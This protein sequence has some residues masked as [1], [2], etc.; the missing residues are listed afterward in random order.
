MLLLLSSFDPALFLCPLLS[1][2]VPWSLL[3]A[4]LIFVLLL[5]GPTLLSLAWLKGC[6]FGFIFG[7]TELPPP[8]F[9]T[10]GLAPFLD[11][12]SA[13]AHRI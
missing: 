13:L 11:F 8:K 4:S 3:E 6:R 1:P 10:H 5:L 7:C 9:M 12:E 2:L